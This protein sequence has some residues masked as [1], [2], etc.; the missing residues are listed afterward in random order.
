MVIWTILTMSATLGIVGLVGLLHECW[1]SARA[2]AVSQGNEAHTHKHAAGVLENRHKS[3][4][5]FSMGGAFPLLASA[6]GRL[7]GNALLFIQPPDF[8]A[9]TFPDVASPP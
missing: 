4:T 3:C 9:H 8:I 1:T 5:A 7:A 6:H 2:S